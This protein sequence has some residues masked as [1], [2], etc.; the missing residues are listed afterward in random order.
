[1]SLLRWPCKLHMLHAVEKTVEISQLQAAEKIVETR[2]TQ[3]IQGIQTSESFKSDDPDAETQVPRGRSASWSWWFYLRCT[4][5]PCCQWFW[6]N[7]DCV[8]GEMWEN[9]PPFS[10]A[11]NRAASDEIARHCKHR[12]ER[13]VRKLHESGTALAKDIEAPVLK[14]AGFE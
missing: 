9:K 7:G 12:T 2:E 14:D 10:L 1:M 5:K 11:L 8:T 4:R 3:T 6:E 13:G